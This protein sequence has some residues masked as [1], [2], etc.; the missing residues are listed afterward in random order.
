[1]SDETI[2][3]RYIF[4]MPEFRRALRCY[5]R[6]SSLKWWL[7]GLALLLLGFALYPLAFP[8]AASAESSAGVSF[9]W[10]ALFWNLLPVA[11]FLAF[12]VLF[13]AYRTW[14]PFRKSVYFEKEMI[15]TFRDSG[16][17]LE[18]PLVQSEMK[19]EAIPR[20][21]ENRAGFALFFSSRNAFSWVPKSGFTS[22]QQIDRCRELFRAR[23][24]NY[25]RLFPAG[26]SVS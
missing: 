23:I 19:W 7:G 15:Y 26:G 11:V 16:V 8:D 21:A 17:H 20:V 6:V 9:S 3:C 4:T 22:T 14:R 24:K 18:T 5:W 12:M 25:R 13:L 2:V 10:T 1:M